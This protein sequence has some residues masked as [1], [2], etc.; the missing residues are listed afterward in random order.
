MKTSSAKAKGRKLQQWV[1]DKIIEA[2]KGFGVDPEDVKSTSM[3]AG[4]EDIQL[5]PFARNYLPVSIE[6]KSHKSMAIY[7]LY[8]QAEANSGRYEPL[9]V[10]KVNNRKPL[11]VVDFEYY[12]KL[13][14]NQHD[15]RVP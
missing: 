6:C 3:G 15:E 1:R 12:L 5:S 10:V 11:A 13:E 4:G 8:D 9:L 2:F 14:R 7:S